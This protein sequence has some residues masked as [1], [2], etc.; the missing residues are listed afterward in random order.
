MLLDE[1]IE[2]STNVLVRIPPFLTS[3]QLPQQQLQ[4]SVHPLGSS[5]NWPHKLSLQLMPL[6]LLKPVPEK[7]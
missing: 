5:G 2:E 6:P 1:I 3:P 7:Y 4:A